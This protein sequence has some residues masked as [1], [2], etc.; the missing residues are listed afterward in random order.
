LTETAAIGSLFSAIVLIAVFFRLA[1]LE[2]RVAALSRLDAKLDALLRHSG[3]VFEPYE[4]VPPGVVDALRRGEKIK[5]IKQYREA[6]G[7]GLKDAK[8]FVE[9]V[10]RRAAIGA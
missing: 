8:D 5:A 1:T 6:T 2:R 3:V 9:E 10:Q 7:A 4:S